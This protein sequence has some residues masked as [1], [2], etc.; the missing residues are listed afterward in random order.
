MRRRTI[1][2]VMASKRTLVVLTAYDYWT[3][4]MVDRA[5]VDMVLIGDSLGMVVQGREN[6]L[7][8]TLDQV[9]YHTQC[10]A[11]GCESALV[12]ADMP[13]LSFHVSREETIR[14]AGRLIQEGGADA[15]KLEGGRKR[16]DTIRALIDAE[17]PVMGH[18]GMT[19]QSVHAMGGFKVQG[20]TEEAAQSLVEDAKA[21]ESAG[22]FSMVLEC[23]PIDVARAITEAVAVPT[24]G[25]GAGPHCRGQVLVTHD[26]LGM[27]F[28]HVPRFVRPFAALAQSGQDALTR[29]CE[30]VRQGDFPTEAEGFSLNGH[31]RQKPQTATTEEQ[32]P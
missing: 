22:V 19:P 21:L 2:G 17:I 12:I 31:R 30:A 18:V 28:S 29:F 3:A 8:V 15:V 4:Q 20:R 10:V 5:G 1:P 14:N 25:I 11:R 7:A 16:A 9:V 32:S 27:T 13:Y 24:I 26:L 23:V 6:T